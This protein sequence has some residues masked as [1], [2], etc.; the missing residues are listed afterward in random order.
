M[1]PKNLK[2]I[3]R[4]VFWSFFV[5]FLLFVIIYYCGAKEAGH[6]EA[7]YDLWKGRYEIRTYGL[8][9]TFALDASIL[10]ANGIDYV[11]FAGCMVNNFII[12]YV[13]GYNF[14]MAKAIKRD[15]EIDV[16]KL[17][18]YGDATVDIKQRFY[19]K[20][21]DLASKG[22]VNEVERPSTILCK[23][24]PKEGENTLYEIGPCSQ[25][26][27]A[28]IDSDDAIETLCF[29]TLKYREYDE[30]HINFSLLVDIFKAGHKVVR[31]ELNRTFYYKEEFVLLQDIDKDG[32]SELVTKV[33]FGPDCAGDQAFRIYKFKK[34]SFDLVLNVFGVPLDN[35][36]IK[37]TLTNLPGFKKRLLDLYQEKRPS[38]H[39]CIPPEELIKSDPWL[40]DPD[41]IGKPGMLLLLVPPY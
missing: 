39:L 35:P 19:E 30:T 28:N 29:R 27:E 3:G 16:K 24:E 2:K 1:I 41:H 15:L 37:T 9:G 20:L 38:E 25:T 21:S 36:F 33:T 34:S 26:V 4:F 22:S 18:N 11:Q 31:Q 17:L 40:I 7:K 14:V 13:A 10:K 8:Q 23:P 5:F 6:L 12:R 32:K